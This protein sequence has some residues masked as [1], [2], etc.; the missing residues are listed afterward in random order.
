[1]GIKMSRVVCDG[2]V[3]YEKEEVDR[4]AIMNARY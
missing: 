3:K 1:M 4:I 2:Y